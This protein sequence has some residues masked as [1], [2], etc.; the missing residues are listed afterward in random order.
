LGKDLV[1]TNTT[2]SA[3]ADMFAKLGFYLNDNQT[4]VTNTGGQ[5][6]PMTPRILGSF[7]RVTKVPAAGCSVMLPS[8]KTMENNLPVVV[9]NDG[10]LTINV[11]AYADAIA[12]NGEYLNGTTS[13]QQSVFGAATGKLS[14]P[15]AT[16]G[17]FLPVGLPSRRGGLPTGNA[18][19][20]SGQVFT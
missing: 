9:I 3:A 10:G 16:F 11:Y 14:I 12:A 8:L 13:A 1:V 18:L 15:T 17:F 5:V 7:M 2:N 4:P 19:Y 20:W 6:G